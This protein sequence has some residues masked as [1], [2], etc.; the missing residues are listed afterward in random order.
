MKPMPDAYEYE[1]V[2]PPSAID[3]NGHVNNVEF[4]R[5]MQEA[6]VR[7]FESVGGG[8]VLAAL[9]AIWVVRTHKVEYLR[10]AMPGE[11]LRVRTCVADFRRVQ[12][13]RKYEFSRAEGGTVLVKGETDWVLVDTARGRP[14]S[15]PEEMRALLPVRPDGN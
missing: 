12:S 6:A 9:G 4:V 7:H 11:R 8:P 13:L 15:I 10:P 14:K 1:F 3:V 5:W 2:V